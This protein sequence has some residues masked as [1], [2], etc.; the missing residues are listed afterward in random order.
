LKLL[1]RSANNKR[2]VLWRAESFKIISPRAD[3]FSP[4]FF[5]T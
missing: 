4:G 1:A 3:F 2:L 5:C